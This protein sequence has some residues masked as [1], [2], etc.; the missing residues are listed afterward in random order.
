MRFSPTNSALR[1]LVLTEMSLT[2][3]ANEFCAQNPER[4]AQFWLPTLALLRAIVERLDGGHWKRRLSAARE[5]VESQ[6]KDGTMKLVR[7]W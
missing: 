4:W 7:P 3:A 6:L 5:D 2:S 1:S